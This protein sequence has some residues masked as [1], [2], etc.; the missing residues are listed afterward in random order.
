MGGCQKGPQQLELLLALCFLHSWSSTLHPASISFSP[1]NGLSEEGFPSASDGKE[2]TFNS[3]DSGSIPGSGRSPGEGNG[4]PLQYSCLKKSM[5][6]GAWWAAVHGFAKSGMTEWLTLSLSWE[7]WLSPLYRC[8]HWVSERL[9]TS[10]RS[11][12]HEA[13]NLGLEQCPG[14][15]QGFAILCYLEQCSSA[16]VLWEVAWREPGR[17]A[18]L[19]AGWQGLQLSHEADSWRRCRM[20]Q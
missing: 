6:R 8:K 10:P 20:G 13:A 15:T 2:S 18:S 9:N 1:L 11:C 3:G 17:G 12:S 19:G 14:R 7:M 5:D 4:Y 16:L